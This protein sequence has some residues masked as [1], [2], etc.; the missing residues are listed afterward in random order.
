MNNFI[1]KIMSFLL[2][3]ILVITPIT[4]AYADREDLSEDSISLSSKDTE[5]PILG[6]NTTSVHQMKKWAISKNANKL[7][8][9]LAP[10]FYEVSIKNGVDPAVTYTQ[11][12]KETGYMKFGG[13]LDASFKN[14]CGLKIPKG[15][16]DKDP[17]AHKVFSS[18]EE[19]ITAQVH[20]LALYAGKEGF[21][22]AGTP[23][24]RHFPYLLGKA[25]T[26][27]ALSKNWAPSPEYGNDIVKMMDNLYTFPFSSTI[28]LSGDNRYD[29]ATKI[30]NSANQG[31]NQTIVIANGNNYADTLI[32]SSLAKNVNGALYITPTNLSKELINLSNSKKIKTAYIVGGEKNIPGMYERFIRSNGAIT[33]RI[34]GLDRY[35][36]AYK[37]ANMQKNKNTVVLV[38]GNE[39]SDTLSITPV[40]TKHNYP[41]LLTNGKTIDKNS[42][43][44]INKSSTVYIAGGESKVS[45]NLENTL[46]K[47]GK[48]V[49]RVSGLDRYETSMNIAKEFFPNATSSIFASGTN[50][51]DAI[52]GVSLSNK[53]DA[54]IFLS[55]KKEPNKNQLDFLKSN[56]TEF[57][58]I[59][60]G[61]TSI[62]ESFE[63]YIK[64]F[65][66]YYL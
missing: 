66:D 25:K 42:M 44:I 2:V 62:S 15:G 1:K 39:F 8:I 31:S 45:K 28:R 38:N 34:S 3:T 54:P 64:S 23:D 65:L 46:K 50:F 32:A 30:R 48:T 55:F 49:K 63:S 12:A 27:E 13:V 61:H 52:S 33:T 60:G 43:S 5:R 4:N 56:K 35:D 18:W 11:S 41:L 51:A 19:G 9:D 59:L 58:Y 40:A 29:T 57:V 37:I 22:K 26:V 24:P 14:P 16:D 17:E 20:H 10:T 6:K 36:S 21:P 7:F 47:S 53:L